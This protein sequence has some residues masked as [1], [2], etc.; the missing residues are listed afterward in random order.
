MK[1]L[2]IHLTDTC[3]NSCIFCVVD[4]I[5]KERNYKAKLIF[6]FLKITK[7]KELK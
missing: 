5:R 7:I 6:E 2:S 1:G 3:N 4:S